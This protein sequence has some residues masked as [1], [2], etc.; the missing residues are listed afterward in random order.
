MLSL[1]LW[2]LVGC[3]IAVFLFYVGSVLLQILGSV[4]ELLFDE[5]C[6]P[7]FWGIIAVVGLVVCLLFI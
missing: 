3:G 5:E 1:A 2:F 4:F 7:V 6:G